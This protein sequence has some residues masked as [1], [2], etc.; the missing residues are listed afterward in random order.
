VIFVAE[1]ND[2]VSDD[3]LWALYKQWCKAFNQE[4]D[5]AEMVQRFETFKRR[6][7]CAPCG[8]S[9]Q[10]SYQRWSVPQ[11]WNKQVH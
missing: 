6:V 2:L 11:T 8:Q 1:E 3:A 9:K 5:H 10:G 4:R 7:Q